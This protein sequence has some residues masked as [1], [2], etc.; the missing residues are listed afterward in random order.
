V[1]QKAGIEVR[2]HPGPCLTVLV[3][4]LVLSGCGT[5]QLSGSAQSKRDVTANAGHPANSVSM[6]DD[7]AIQVQLTEF[8]IEMPIDKTDAGVTVF[9]ITNVGSLEHNFEI[10]RRD[11]GNEKYSINV[12]PGETR[13]LRTE[14]KPGTYLVY[15]PV[16]GVDERGYA[17][18]LVVS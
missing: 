10:E 3:F 17:L 12:K 11:N 5:K 1:K 13:M 16:P 9:E 7:F 2:I 6:P 4:S 15:W 14:L 18:Q 8:N